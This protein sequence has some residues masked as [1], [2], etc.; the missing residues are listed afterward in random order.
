M[1]LAAFR[2]KLSLVLRL[3]TGERPGVA[4]C[5][6]GLSRVAAG[7]GEEERGAELLEAATTLREAAG[8]LL[9]T[10]DPLAYNPPLS[11]AELALEEDVHV[12]AYA[13]GCAFLLDQA[14]AEAIEMAHTLSAARSVASRRER[15]GGLT[16]REVEVLRLLAA[17][18]SNRQIADELALSFHTVIR[19][20]NHI[21]AKIGVGNRTE[22]S[23]R[24][25]E[26]DLL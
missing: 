2:Y 7:Q 8:A 16:R 19:H 25:R 26:L 1:A 3:R 9:P 17:G 12:D 5:L 13:E 14:V 20:V 18:K 21:F 24:A 4:E 22:A 10:S 6:E 15:P 23:A 11:D